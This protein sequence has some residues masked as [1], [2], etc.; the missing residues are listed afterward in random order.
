MVFLCW[1]GTDGRTCRR[2]AIDQTTITRLAAAAA[3]VVAG[4]AAAWL[5]T[6]QSVP[7]G[8]AAAAAAAPGVAAASP[9][10]AGVVMVHVSGAVAEPGLVELRMGSRLADAVAAAGG[11]VRGADLSQVNLAAPVRD[12]ERVHIPAASR[13]GPV[14]VVSAD[15]R[16]RINQAGP[17]ELES[18]PGV[19]PVLAGR[20]V[21]FRDEHG[22]FD[23]PEDLLDVPGLGEAKLAAMRDVIAIP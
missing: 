18:I 13:D 19:G 10:V 12:G 21:A 3:V 8:A 23:A 17:T 11:I 6:P 7:A 2:F 22:P 9:D 16:I 14:S 15:G 4:A 1:H 5:W 20:I